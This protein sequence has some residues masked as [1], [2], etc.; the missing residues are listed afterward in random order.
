MSETIQVMLVEDNAEYREVISLALDQEVDLELIAQ[1]GSA[2]VALRSLQG[3]KVEKV[4]DLILL[5]IRLPGMSGLESLS[6]FQEEVPDTKIV[7][8]TQSNEEADVL[9]AISGGAAG[10]LLKSSTAKQISEG[11]RKVME[12]GATLDASVAKFVLDT[13]QT[14]LPEAELEK[15]SLT[16]RELEV[17]ALISEGLV[18]KEIAERLSI[19]YT[20]VDSHVGHIYEKLKVRNAPAAVN[21]AHRMGLFQFMPK[22]RRK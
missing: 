3:R 10:Y 15:P 8:L 17:L 7:M 19:S 4:P 11:I 16:K 6:W 5:D 20:T 12:G 21:Q 2:E 14:R 9:L 22:G 13:L 1:F 18:K